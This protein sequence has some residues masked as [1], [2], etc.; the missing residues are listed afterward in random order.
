[1][2]LRFTKM[3]GLGNDFVVFDGIYQDL[4]PILKPYI[5]S[6]IANR[7]FGVGC[8]QILIVEP[9]TNHQNDFKYRIFNADGGE[10]EQCG[11]GAR[12][13]A[14]FVFDKKLTKKRELHV[15]TAKGVIIP[16]IEDNGQITVNMGIPIFDPK[17][18]PL[19]MSSQELVY[20]LSIN[21]QIHTISV[22]SMGNPHA[23]ISLDAV[24]DLKTL[25]INALSQAIQQS[26]YFPESVNVGFMK[27]INNHQIDLRVYERGCGETL[28]CGSGACGAVVSGIRLG[29]LDKIVKVNTHGGEL[30]IRWE[31][32]NQPVFM[33]GPAETVFEGIFEL[34]ALLHDLKA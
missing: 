26:I 4:T 11:N 31:G 32:E 16:K 5:L 20:E 13:F 10:V 22:V 27:I 33:T 28:A 25:E 12:C 21:N 23:V 1:M 15:E 9:A 34:N 2:S 24:V 14:K 3:H 19:N 29:Q 18:I 30:T 17:K 6:K 7:H 8:D